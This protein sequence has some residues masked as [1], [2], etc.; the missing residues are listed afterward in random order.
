MHLMNMVQ[1][2]SK[3]IKLLLTDFKQAGC[4]GRPDVAAAGA[5]IGL[6]VAQ[7]AAA[8]AGLLQLGGLKPL[9]AILHQ[10]TLAEQSVAANVLFDMSQ[11]NLGQHSVQAC[12]RVGP[13]M[14]AYACSCAEL[15]S[16]RASYCCRCCFRLMSHLKLQPSPMWS[17]TNDV[18]KMY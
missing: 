3:L 6:L 16:V 12:C 14:S 13:I 4:G 18:I 11:G 15:S 7:Q 9:L 17:A 10:G 1:R 5:A 2:L 8:R